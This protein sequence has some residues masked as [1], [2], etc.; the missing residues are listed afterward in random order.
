MADRRL[1]RLF[2][3]PYKGWRLHEYEVVCVPLP[4]GAQIVEIEVA[5][6]D[7]R[8]ELLLRILKEKPNG[9][10]EGTEKGTA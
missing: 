9:L 2:R 6:Y 1:S 3:V 5:E 4:K 8:N 10:A 7:D